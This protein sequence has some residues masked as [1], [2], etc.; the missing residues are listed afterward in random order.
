MFH[1]RYSLCV[2]W[3]LALLVIPVVLNGCAN[4]EY[5]GLNVATVVAPNGEEW[6]IISGKDQ[7]NTRL[8]IERGDVVIHYSSE[9]ED[10]SA[11]LA[12]AMQH[13]AD[14]LRAIVDLLKTMTPGPAL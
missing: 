8:D 6:Q 7:T 14:T 3:G 11:A 12:I 4:S 10:A 9:K 5:A 1:R 13:Q 2:V